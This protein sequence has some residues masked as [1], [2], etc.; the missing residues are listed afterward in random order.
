MFRFHERS[1]CYCH[2]RIGAIS[3]HLFALCEHV[4]GPYS[5][6]RELLFQSRACFTITTTFQLNEI[7]TDRSTQKSL[8]SI[9]NCWS[10]MLQ[11]QRVGI[12]LIY[13]PKPLITFIVSQIYQ[14]YLDPDHPDR[15]SKRIQWCLNVYLGN[16]NAIDVSKFTFY[17][18]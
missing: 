17:F 15:Q 3:Q 8:I 16:T 11:L 14:I 6:K 18:N 1:T 12:I 2:R 5:W 13:C 9:Y 10:L 7:I 4:T